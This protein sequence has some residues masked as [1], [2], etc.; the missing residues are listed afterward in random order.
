[1]P[2]DT[3]EL[4]AAAESPNIT[5]R[6]WVVDSALIFASIA[7]LTMFV[8]L[9]LEF[10]FRI[11]EKDYL[12]DGDTHVFRVCRAMASS[13]PAAAIVGAVAGYETYRAA[14]GTRS[15][16]RPLGRLLWYGGVVVFAF[17]HAAHDTAIAAMFFGPMLLGY[18][19]EVRAMPTGTAQRSWITVLACLFCPLLYVVDACSSLSSLHLDDRLAASAYTSLWFSDCIANHLIMRLRHRLAPL[20]SDRF[21]FSLSTLLTLVLLLGAYVTMLVV[22]FGKR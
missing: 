19:Y 22:L 6:R 21:Q 11:E 13:L 15:I 8:L 12:A 3:D 2:A 9:R 10:V 18:A 1:M 14:L 7:G 4:R 16:S 20:S 17:D 5:L